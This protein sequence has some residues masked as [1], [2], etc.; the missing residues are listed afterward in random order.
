MQ[1]SSQAAAQDRVNG[2]WKRMAKAGRCDALGEVESPPLLAEAVIGLL[3]RVAELE[4][5]RRVLEFSTSAV[6]LPGRL[7]R[8][9][10]TR[11]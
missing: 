9:E 7:N 8:F 10:A 5:P 3:A 11:L 4:R 2:E 1:R 6:M